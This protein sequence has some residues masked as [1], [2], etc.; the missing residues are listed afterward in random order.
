MHS[1]PDD[2]P[3]ADAGAGLSAQAALETQLDAE[4][5]ALWHAQA[6]PA[7][8]DFVARVMA[9]LPTAQ[10]LPSLSPRNAAVPQAAAVLRRLARLL[11]I[12]ACGA[13]GAFEALSFVA[14]LWS[15][16]AVALG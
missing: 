11:A 10:A 5:E 12:A 4:L 1:S 15:A 2:R 3:K 14:T 13:G 6:M 9:A 16:S 8:V 7:P